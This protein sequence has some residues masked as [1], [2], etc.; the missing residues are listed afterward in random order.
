MNWEPEV[1]KIALWLTTF[2][3]AQPQGMQNKIILV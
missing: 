2:Y 3:E 1:H